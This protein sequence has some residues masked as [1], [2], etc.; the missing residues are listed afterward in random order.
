MKKSMHC[1]NTKFNYSARK[2]YDLNSVNQ[3]SNTIIA[4]VQQTLS[5]EQTLVL[6][7][8]ARALI[9]NNFA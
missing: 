2:S 5:T 9:H 7:D 3:F 1:F 4:I 8:S 6:I